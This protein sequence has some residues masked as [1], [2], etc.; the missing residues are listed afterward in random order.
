MF[1]YCYLDF[2]FNVIFSNIDF[3]LFVFWFRTMRFL[4]VIIDRQS[5]PKSNVLDSIIM[6]SGRIF[7]RLLRL[8][9]NI[10]PV[11]CAATVQW[12]CSPGIRKTFGIFGQPRV[13]D[14]RDNHLNC[15]ITGQTA[16]VSNNDGTLCAVGWCRFARY[17]VDKK[18]YIIV[19]G[20]RNQNEKVK[21]PYRGFKLFEN[22][23][24]PHYP[25]QN[26]H[27]KPS[28]TLEWTRNCEATKVQCR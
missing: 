1:S 25:R 22:T 11:H 27:G 23:P 8:R 12:P 13:L 2:L 4:I 14:G 9:V 7:P 15:W 17:G 26:V 10:I 6:Y 3:C 19:T 21:H 5:L 16:T 20:R 24:S 28:S 18:P